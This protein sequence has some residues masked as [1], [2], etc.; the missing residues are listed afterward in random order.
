[1][2]KANAGRAPGR[3]PWPGL[4]GPRLGVLQTLGRW[5]GAWYVELAR[6]GYLHHGPFHEAPRSVAFFPLYPLVVRGASTL[7]RLS[8]LV[9]AVAL[10]TLLGALAIVLIWRLTLEI[11]DRATADRAALLVAF[12]PGALVL[13]MAYAEPLMLVGASGCLLALLHRRWVVAGLLAAATT[14]TRPNAVVI[15][16]VC[17]WAAIAALRSRGD[18]RT[19]IAPALAPLG[20]VAW[21]GWLWARTGHP[22]AWFRAERNAWGDRTGIGLSTFHHVRHLLTRGGVSLHSTDLNELLWGLG[23]VFVVVTIAALW[24]WRPPAPLTVYALASIALALASE[25]VGPRP[26]LLL[27]AFPLVVAAAVKV[28]GRPF[29][30]LVGASAVALGALSVITFG[31]LAA[32]P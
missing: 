9:V 6:R 12:F 21:F 16:L 13:S 29:A 22:L 4:P 5:D 3:G 26:R 18:R 11:T 23:A 27:T 20:I 2:A 30:L 14:A 8:P 19:L 17:A 31:T 25:N 28:R 24:R 32:T 7:T 1:M 10:S 15:V